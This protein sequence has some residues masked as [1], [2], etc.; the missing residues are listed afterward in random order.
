MFII[1]Q[2]SYKVQSKN[3]IL[4]DSTIF[5]KWQVC[6]FFPCIVPELDVLPPEG[7]Q[8]PETYLHV[9]C[10]LYRLLKVCLKNPSGSILG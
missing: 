1:F 6:L 2:F 10:E 9:K 5:P 7:I 8:S 4:H 3:I